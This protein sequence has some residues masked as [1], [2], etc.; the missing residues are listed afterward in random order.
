MISIPM[1]MILL[2]AEIC[3]FTLQGHFIFI[4]NFS[5]FS[6]RLINFFHLDFPV[7]KPQKLQ[8]KNVVSFIC[9]CC[10]V[11][12][13]GVALVVIVSEESGY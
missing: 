10:V 9:S 2:S 6:P 4:D 1:N 8:L 11:M 7:A 12:K 5:C 13:G 3:R